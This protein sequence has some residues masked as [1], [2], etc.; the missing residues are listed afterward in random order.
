MAPTQTAPPTRYWPNAL[1]R[2]LNFCAFVVALACLSFDSFARS[3]SML[4]ITCAEQRLP[5]HS[6]RSFSRSLSLSLNCGL[7]QR[8]CRFGRRR[9]G[10]FVG[11]QLR[12]RRRRAQVTATVALTQTLTKSKTTTT[13]TRKPRRRRQ[14]RRRRLQRSLANTT[15]RPTRSAPQPKVF[16]AN[17]R[18]T[19]ERRSRAALC[20]PQAR[21]SA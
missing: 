11:R 21:P 13:T 15:H 17:F 1:W 12:R 7:L 9:V 6:A 20:A 2:S 10:L 8:L 18:R 4:I 19:S 5:H 14:R 16:A 3:V